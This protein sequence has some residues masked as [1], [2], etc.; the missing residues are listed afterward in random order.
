MDIIK[1]ALARE[2]AESEVGLGTDAFAANNHVKGQSVRKRYCQ[3]GSYFGV[4][5]VKLANR[6][7]LWPAVIVTRDIAKVGNDESIAGESGVAG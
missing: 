6:R 3:T 1:M 2:K 4:R 5:P 7:L